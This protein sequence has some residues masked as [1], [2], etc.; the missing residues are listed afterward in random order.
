MGARLLGVDP[1]VRASVMVA[2]FAALT[3]DLSRGD[4]RA[5]VALRAFLPA[6]KHASYLNALAP[7]DGVRFLDRRPKA[8]LL[9]QLARNDEFISRLDGA[10]FAAAAGEPVDTTWHDGGHFDLGKGPARDERRSFLIRS[11]APGPAAR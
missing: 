9:V 6:E 10:L 4:R 7:L 2:G 11:L 8:P 1:R 3:L 5:A